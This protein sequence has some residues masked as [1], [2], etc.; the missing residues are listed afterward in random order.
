M[1]DDRTERPDFIAAQGDPRATEHVQL[2]GTVTLIVAD[3]R[4][5]KLVQD[6]WAARNTL[7]IVRMMLE[8]LVSRESSTA[9]AIQQLRTTLDA[10]I[11][12]TKQ[13]EELIMA[14]TTDLEAKVAANTTVIESAIT[15]LG[16]LKAALDAAGTDPVKL[17]ALAATLADEDGKLSAAVAA[18]TP[19]APPAPP[20]P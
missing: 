6:V 13:Q 18:N 12:D 17:A 4:I 15:L 16:G 7:A 3:P 10:F 1:S 2:S 8:N 9:A 11:T 19:G 14:D 20:A 5:D